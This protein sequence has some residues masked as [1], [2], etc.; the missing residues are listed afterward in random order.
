MGSIHQPHSSPEE[1]C[2]SIPVSLLRRRRRV[3]EVPL[4]T[5]LAEEAESNHPAKPAR[6]GD[7]L[8]TAEDDRGNH[9]LNRMAFK[10]TALRR[11]CPVIHCP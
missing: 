3:Q 2:L 9:G 7:N 1:S 11:Q 5:A 8:T 10:P 6:K 4:F